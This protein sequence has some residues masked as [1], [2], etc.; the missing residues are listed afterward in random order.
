[1]REWQNQSHVRWYKPGQHLRYAGAE[2][3]QLYPVY[4]ISTSN[5]AA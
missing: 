3:N 1:M 2:L 4:I 5:H